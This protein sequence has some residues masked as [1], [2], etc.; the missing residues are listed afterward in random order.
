[1]HL[2][3]AFLFLTIFDLALLFHIPREW[4]DSPLKIALW[5]LFYVAGLIILEAQCFW[6]YRIP[7]GNGKNILVFFT[8]FYQVVFPLIFSYLIL[9]DF[10]KLIFRITKHTVNP[11]YTFLNA[12]IF[13]MTLMW[14][15]VLFLFL[16]GFIRTMFLANTEYKVSSAPTTTAVQPEVSGNSLRI[17]AV[18]DLHLG[19]GTNG[20]QLHKLAERLREEDPDVIFVLGDLYDETTSADIMKRFTEEFGQLSPKY[21]KYYIY[22]NHDLVCNYEI[23]PSILEAGCR[24]LNNELVDVGGVSVIGLFDDVPEGGAVVSD[25]LKENGVDPDTPVILLNHRPKKLEQFKDTGVDLVLCGHTHGGRYGVER[26]AM[27]L[28]NYPVYGRVMIGEMTA[29]TTS[30]VG[31]WGYRCKVVPP[32]EFI[33]VEYS[34]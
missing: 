15:L 32:N 34:Y 6:D 8:T 7:D 12:K 17:A 25:L 31:A 30:G 10:I 21:G 13:N 11:V 29:I 9:T 20:N 18:A 28:K 24:I 2:K 19:N 3:L 4:R 14:C 26:Q 27:R 23:E 1:M 16:F 5:V 22:G 33:T